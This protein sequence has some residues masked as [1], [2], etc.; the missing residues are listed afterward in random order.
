MT[1][2]LVPNAQCIARPPV[3]TFRTSSNSYG[4]ANGIWPAGLTG[5]GGTLCCHDDAGGS[6]CTPAA[7]ATVAAHAKPAMAE[8]ARAVAVCATLAPTQRGIPGVLQQPIERI[9]EARRKTLI[10]GFRA[11]G[12]LE[13]FL[14]QTLAGLML[15]ALGVEILT[16]GEDIDAG[17]AK[18][19]RMRS[20][21]SLSWTSRLQ[22]GSF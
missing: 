4:N 11:R 20:S 1:K 7:A 21:R 9:C 15:Q 3:A 17:V 16:H 18:H 14:L 6:R 13:S 8:A 12:M 10:C 19:P 5:P 2:R 22:S